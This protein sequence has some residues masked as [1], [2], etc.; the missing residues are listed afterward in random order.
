MWHNYNPPCALD[1]AAGSWVAA[2]KL[3]KSTALPVVNI[4]TY[5]IVYILVVSFGERPPPHIPLYWDAVAENSKVP[6]RRSPKSIALPCVAIVIKL[7]TLVTEL[8]P[9]AIK[10]LVELEQAALE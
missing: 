6:E 8:S 3:P 9:P 10:A 2:S 4:S 1:V 5:W 7:M